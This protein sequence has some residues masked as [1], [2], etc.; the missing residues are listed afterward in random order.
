MVVVLVLAVYGLARLTTG[1]DGS[2]SLRPDGR[3]VSVLKDPE[4][5]TA[6]AP[7]LHSMPTGWTATSSP[8]VESG[9]DACSA[10]TERQ[11]EGVLS[12]ARSSF[13]NAYDQSAFFLV[14]ACASADAARR[15]YEDLAGQPA[16]PAARAQTT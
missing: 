10:S 7:D 8:R 5:V 2:S 13:R 9:G 15:V 3:R 14:T 12:V 11:C 4:T 6:I 1:G 16:D